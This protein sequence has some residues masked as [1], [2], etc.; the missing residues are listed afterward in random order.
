MLNCQEYISF[1]VETNSALLTLEGGT[2]ITNLYA[3]GS[4]LGG[5]NAVSEG[6]GAGVA[7]LTALAVAHTIKG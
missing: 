1:G 7:L 3:I 6:C 5:C 4:V 2:P